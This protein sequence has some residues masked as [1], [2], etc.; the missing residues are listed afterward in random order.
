MAE[1]CIEA[2]GK[3]R[4]SQVSALKLDGRNVDSRRSLEALSLTDGVFITGGNR[5]RLT[6]KICDTKFFEA[7]V[8]RY[9]EENFVI[10]GT[11]AG[12]KAMSAVMISEGSGTESLLKGIVKLQGGFKLLPNTIIDTHFMS[13][14]RFSRLAEALLMQDGYT[15]L[16]I[17]E[18]TGLV[19]S[20]GNI[21]RTIRPGVVM[22]LQADQV[23]KTNF[24]EAKNMQPVYVEGMSM[25]ILAKGASYS[26]STREFIVE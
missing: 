24:K 11:S 15:A 13:R 3:L 14:G 9:Q 18:D 8:R 10:A 23:T 1:M 21:L 25:H 4:C 26:L 17:C 20:E 19:I 6:D 22:L 16:G 2:F 5:T 12:A 7:L